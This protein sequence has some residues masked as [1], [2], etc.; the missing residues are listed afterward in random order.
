M[1]STFNHNK[2]RNSGLVFEFLV[3]QM[4]AGL[5]DKDQ[6]VY[7][8]SL[9]LIRKYF[10]EGTPLGSERLLFEAFRENR[11]VTEGA[12][13]RVIEEVKRLA[14]ALDHKK[15]EI[16][17]SNLIKELNHTF[18]RDFFNRHRIPEYRL[19]A[20]IQML[21]DGCVEAKPLQE[22]VQQIRIEEA[23]VRFMTAP[24]TVQTVSSDEVK[25]DG[26]VCALAAKK[27]QE[28][29]GQALTEGQNRILMGYMRSTITGDKARLAKLLEEQKQEILKSLSES[30]GLKEFKEDPV[31]AEKNSQAIN[32]LR[33]LDVSSPEEGTV[34]E[35]MLFR[36]LMEEV[37][38]NG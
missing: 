15:I 20:S 28:K 29:Y 31:M 25:V 7:Q 17:K 30:K 6:K 22:S 36:K 24:E 27:F 33:A 26:L 19:L 10:G 12:A 32:R 4:G 18:G 38:S 34:E 23:L 13:W 2:K 21:I 16:K 35:V 14:K 5:I 3:R 8:E 9:S 11:G 1:S 37:R